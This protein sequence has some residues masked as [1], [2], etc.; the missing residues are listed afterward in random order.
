MA[1]NVSSGENKAGTRKGKMKH[2]DRKKKVL[3][4]CTHNSARSQMAEGL[5]RAAYGRRYDVYS[6]GT[7]PSG[8]NPHAVRVMAELGID[9]SG[10][11]SK[12]VDRFKEETFDIVVTVCQRAKEACPIFPGG[13]NYLHEDFEEPSELKGTANEI[14]AGFRRIRDEM[15]EWIMKNF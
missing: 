12:S 11:H 10:H 3:F 13:G 15:R 6:A 4:V 8:V 2:A 5:L 7:E 9:I 1:Q 14:L